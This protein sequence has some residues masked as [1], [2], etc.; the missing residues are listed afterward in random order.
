VRDRPAN[1]P[2]ILQNCI[3]F[4]FCKIWRRKKL[5]NYSCLL[6]NLLIYRYLYYIYTFLLFSHSRLKANAM[7][8]CN[9]LL[10]FPPRTPKRPD[11]DSETTGA[12][13]RSN[14]AGGERE[15]CFFTP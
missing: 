8:L 5:V 6:Y 1:H 2:Q 11:R 4:H 12:P 10:P 15:W 13:L 14:R 9:I 7:Q 3:A